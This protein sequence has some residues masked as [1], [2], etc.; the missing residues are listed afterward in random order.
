MGAPK[1]S[2]ATGK[3]EAEA[4]FDLIVL[5]NLT[6]RIVGGV[7]DTTSVNTGI[8]NGV[9]AFLERFLNRAL[10]HFACRHHVSEL[11]LKDVYESCLGALKGSEVVIF[12]SFRRIWP[13]I[14]KSNFE[15]GMSDPYTKKI[16]EA[17]KDSI[18]QFCCAQLQVKN[19]IVTP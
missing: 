6:L 16:I 9:M 5:W 15:T 12:N 3:L 2:T 7:F 1:V 11:M 18:I 4:V 13:N 19:A 14:D 10:L 8:H 17:D